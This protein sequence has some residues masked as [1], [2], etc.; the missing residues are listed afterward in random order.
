MR[1]SR[2]EHHTYVTSKYGDR[3]RRPRNYLEASKR[4]R[5]RA[6]WF[7]A[8]LYVGGHL[9]LTLAGRKTQQTKYRNIHFL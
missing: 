3:V 2:V 4:E 7:F 1:G 9:S 6:T 5:G 8:E